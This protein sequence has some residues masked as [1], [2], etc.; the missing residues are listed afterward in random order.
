MPRDSATAPARFL[1][2]PVTTFRRLTPRS[3]LLTLAVARGAFRFRAGQAV[4]LGRHGQAER[5]P[6]SIASAPDDLLRTGVLQFLVGLDADGEAGPHLSPL[7]RGTPVDV[8]GP[9]GGFALPDTAPSVPVLLVAGGT[10]IAPLRSM[11]RA[12]LRAKHPPAITVIY[13]ART[14][15]ELAFLRE[16]ERLAAGG[17]IA[18]AVTVT[19]QDPHWHGSRGRVTRALLAAQVPDARNVRCAICGPGGFVEHVRHG[20]DA[21][22]VPSERIATE[23]W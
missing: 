18:L 4:W 21:L 8:V 11:M 19:G 20:L 3:R 5:K 23:Q 6:Y 12:L 16:L 1:V 15:E 13:S 7:A 17:R 14:S 9:S 10:G 2:L 22:G